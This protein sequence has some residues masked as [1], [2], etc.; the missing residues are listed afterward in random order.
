MQIML[1]AVLVLHVLAAVFWAGSTFTLARM[2]GERAEQFFAPQMG[3]AAVTALTGFVLW[4]QLHS[5]TFGVAEQILAAGV[6]AALL[7]AGVQ[8]SLIAGA[9]PTIGAASGAGATALRRRMAVGERIA[10]GLLAVALIAMTVVRF[11]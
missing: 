8:A 4:W 2:A 5:G 9:Q 10:A 6:A 3:A 1:M 11:V 7:A